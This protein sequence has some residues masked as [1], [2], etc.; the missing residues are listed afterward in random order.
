MT[1]TIPLVH[2]T[3]A[4]CACCIFQASRITGTEQKCGQVFAVPNLFP[5]L[6]STRRQRQRRHAPCWNEHSD[7]ERQQ[8][9]VM[10]LT[11]T[12]CR[13]VQLCKH[14]ITKTSGSR[15]LSRSLLMHITLGNSY[16]TSFAPSG[17][18]FYSRCTGSTNR[19]E[20]KILTSYGYFVWTRISTMT[21]AAARCEPYKCYC[22]GKTYLPLNCK[23][24]FLFGVILLT[25]K[26]CFRSD[27]HRRCTGN[28]T[29]P[30]FEG[31]YLRVN[32]F[33]NNNNERVI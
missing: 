10:T 30:T 15:P 24:V 11:V 20:S 4:V 12:C 14:D 23:F 32:T 1:S 2:K 33:G 13:G 18:S 28:K 17:V 31:K 9:R 25:E 16:L 3:D 21:N 27:F 26:F 7:D 29:R 22:M 5:L 8:R 19:T 6:T